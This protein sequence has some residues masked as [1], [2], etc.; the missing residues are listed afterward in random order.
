MLYPPLPVQ[1]LYQLS[2]G[3]SPSPSALPLPSQRSS[4]PP[5][6]PP[7]PVSGADVPLYPAS[8]QSTPL[9][10][11]RVCVASPM[12][13]PLSPPPL[14]KPCSCPLLITSPCFWCR[15]ASIPRFQSMHSMHLIQAVAACLR[16]FPPPYAQLTTSPCFW[17]RCASIP[18]FQSRYFCRLMRWCTSWSVSPRIASL[19]TSVN[20]CKNV[21][22]CGKCGTYT[23]WS[24]SWSVSPRIASLHTSVS[25]FEV[26]KGVR[27]WE[28]R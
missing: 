23:S 11:F 9:T 22:T 8:S 19:H 7:A 14:P 21:G 6:S 13:S 5:F 3:V 18:R 12:P 10:W 1:A 27:M 28:Q 4:P 20:V 17:C 26:W 2:Q 25:V 24:T 15:C 16:H